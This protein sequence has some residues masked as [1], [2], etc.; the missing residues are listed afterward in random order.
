MKCKKCDQDKDKSEFYAHTATECK[1]CIKKR[2]RLREQI[3]KSD[4]VWYAAERKRHRQKYHRLGY[5]EKHKPTPEM[6]KATMDRYKKKYPEKI[7]AHL[8]ILGKNIVAKDKENH[9]HHW[10]Y[11]K[12]HWIDTV[13]LN[14]VDHN[15]IHRFIIY[16]QER[17]MY[18]RIDT[19][20][21]LDTKEKHIAYFESIKHLD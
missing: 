3:L 16:D 21:L 11:N 14:A 10:S 7:N 13:E 9:L 1:S 6:R 5:K 4:P 15:K 8:Y 20:E 17:M 19:H 12:E 18:R 2:V